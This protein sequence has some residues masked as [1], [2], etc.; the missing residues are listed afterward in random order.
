MKHCLTTV[1]HEGGCRPW[2][3][4]NA[5]VLVLRLCNQML[6]RPMDLV[7]FAAQVECEVNFSVFWF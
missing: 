3:K 2:S 1:Q 6:S 4:L 7:T 5:L